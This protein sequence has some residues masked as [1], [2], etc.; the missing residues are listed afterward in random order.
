MSLPINERLRQ[1][2][3]HQGMTQEQLA[4]LTHVS[5]QT[6]SNWE[7][8]R[9]A[10]DYDMLRALAEALNTSAS[11]L[12]GEAEEPTPE[13]AG[14]DLPTVL[15]PQPQKP[16]SAL[17]ILAIAACLFILA[18][19]MLAVSLAPAQPSPPPVSMEWFQKES[20]PVEGEPFLQITTASSPVLRTYIGSEDHYCWQYTLRFN[21]TGGVPCKVL[22]I[23][24]YFFF[25]NGGWS[26]EEHT[27]KALSLG[28]G[29]I[30][31]GST[32]LME[33]MDSTITPM[34]GRGVLI[35]AADEAGKEYEFH[36]FI[37]YAMDY[38]RP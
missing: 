4:Q 29:D 26:V 16:K 19:A 3:K 5:R 35:K 33:C 2:R 15:P 23:Q 38:E 7:T 10:P 22:S 13:M 30:G 32:R 21:E 8:G 31:A 1:L 37:P 36:S 12:L 28:N 18:G 24:F 11:D 25:L 9:A 20:V 34:Y 17:W 6:I 27:P 14:P